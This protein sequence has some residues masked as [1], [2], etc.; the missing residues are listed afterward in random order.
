ME[1]LSSR[2]NAY[3]AHMRALAA[4][5]QYRLE[6]QQYLCDGIKTL[7]EALQFG[8]QVKSLLWKGEAQQVEGLCCKEQY[9]APA[10]LFDYACPLKNSPGPLFAVQMPLR[11]ESGR[12]EKVIVLENLQDPGNVGTVIR[13]ANAFGMDAVV[14]VGNCADLY[15]PKTVRASMGAIFRQRVVQTDMQ[16]L[17][18]LLKANSLRLCG[19]ALSDSAKEIGST[20]LKSTAVAIGSEGQGLSREFLSR[21][22]GQLIIP[23]EEHSESL[24]AAVAA[25]IVMWEMR[26]K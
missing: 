13:T 16:G 21:C 25:A 19:A 3:I 17:E 11:E 23:M 12:L 5:R 15:N 10:E 18:E 24:N 4:D 1:K 26:G 22:D 2:K 20:E 7:K 6:Q 9:I 14:L 8:A